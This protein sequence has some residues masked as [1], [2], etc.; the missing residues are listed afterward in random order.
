MD[1]PLGTE[2]TLGTDSERRVCEEGGIDHL[3]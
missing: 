1:C 2:G 3:W